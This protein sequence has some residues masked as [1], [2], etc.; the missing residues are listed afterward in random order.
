VPTLTLLYQA[1]HSAQPTL[2]GVSLEFARRQEHFEILAEQSV[3][4]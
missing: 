2:A 1:S 3:M 4:A